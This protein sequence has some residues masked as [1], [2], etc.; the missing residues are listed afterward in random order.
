MSNRLQ[1]INLTDFTG[2]V[3]TT[4]SDF[5]LKPN[6]S[7]AMLNME[8]DP[9][10]GFYTRPGWSRWNPSDI[11]PN[12]TDNWRPRSAQLHPY[13]NGTFSVFVTNANKCWVGASNTS[14]VDLGAVCTA[15]PHLADPA[16]WGSTVYLGCGR[17]N[18]CWK[19]TNQPVAGN[20][21]AALTVAQGTTPAPPGNWNNNYTVPVRGVMPACDHLEPHAGYLFCASTLEDGVAYQNRIRWSH[22]DEPEDWA[23][24][25][26]I[27]IEQGGSAITAIRSFN[28]HLLIFKIDSVWALY[29]YD[30][31]SW[32]LIKVS[33]SVGTPSP[34]AVT[35]SEDAVYFYSSTG[36]NGVYVYGG[37][38]PQEISRTQRW[39]FDNLANT[40]DIWLSWMARRLWCSI[41]WEWESLNDKSHG[42]LLIFDPEHNSWIRHKPAYGT[43]ACTVEYSDVAAEY[44]LVVTC[45]CTDVAGL[46]SVERQPNIA[47][48]VFVQGQS[49]TGYR[50]RYRTSWQDAQW[51]ERQKSFLRPRLVARVSPSEVTVRITTYWNYDPS[52]SRRSHVFSIAAGGGIFWRA[53]GE[54]DPKGG[55]FNWGPA[56]GTGPTPGS[57]AVWGAGISDRYGDVLLRPKVANSAS[58]GTSL[59]WARAVQ[60]EFA[61]DDYTLALPWG[62]DA[63]VLKVNLRGLTT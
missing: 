48:D 20:L 58:R 59:G 18:P 39:V 19:V 38:Q 7:P 6:E 53:E 31:D 34:T 1:T 45:G 25:D 14:F 3:N 22:P 35:R 47:G 8:V 9:Y 41:P 49:A 17:N 12:P 51:P 37:Q 28:D 26:H 2:G 10:G 46:L 29:G 57:G 16:G 15:A 30:A 5:Q 63:I 42:S 27:D 56:P 60:L 33:A 43:V 4:R 52:A 23:Y 36:R 54:A 55:G 13:P 11:I 62:I 61:P 24:E 21:G 40:T 32:Q 44:P 50:C